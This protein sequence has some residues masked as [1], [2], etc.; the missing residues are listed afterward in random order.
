MIRT[1]DVLREDAG[2][3]ARG[4]V[5]GAQGEAAITLDEELYAT[6]ER[7]WRRKKASEGQVRFCKGLGC[8]VPGMESWR[9]G[10][11]SDAISVTKAS[12]R[13]DA[14]ITKRLG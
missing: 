4:D 3:A 12:G 6:R 13:L 1:L 9:A 11:V 8:Y 2:H 5:G 14:M 10:A 7:S